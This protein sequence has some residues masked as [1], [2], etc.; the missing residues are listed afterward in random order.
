MYRSRHPT[1]LKFCFLVSW[2]ESRW[3]LIAGRIPGRTDNEIKNYWNTHLSKKL[4]SQG[5]DP[6]THKP[7]ISSTS[8]TGPDPLLPKGPK[9][10]P[11]A[12]MPRRNPNPV[13]NPIPPTPS[14]LQ[15]TR[16]DRG[17]PGIH[18]D[19]NGFFS[20]LSP[21]PYGGWQ[22]AEGFPTLD[23]LGSQVGGDSGEGGI[24]CCTDDVFSFLD[25][26]INDDNIVLQNQ[27]PDVDY[28]DNNNNSKD[29]QI[30]STDPIKSSEPGFGLRTLWESTITSP[31][32]LDE[33]IR[34]QFVDHA[35]K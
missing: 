30:Q 5:I 19:Q 8:T 31:V 34:G 22:N 12:T 3:S 28:N 1:C 2:N 32:S 26:L 35:G 11:P 10:Q 15:Q 9:I 6:R 29:G 27:H 33:E 13:E 24:D 25:S 14:V 4:I 23:L 20:E 18:G 17:G 21:E 7:L 16:G